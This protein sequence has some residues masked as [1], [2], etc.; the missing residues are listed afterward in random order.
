M[1]VL[2][3]NRWQIALFLYLA[4]LAI[5]LIAKPAMMFT[6][7]GRP[8]TWGVDTNEETSVFSPMIMFPLLGILCYYVG[9]WLELVW[10]T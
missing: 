1:A 6:P 7:E 9:V 5:L 3:V 8:K 4:I 10:D 2:R